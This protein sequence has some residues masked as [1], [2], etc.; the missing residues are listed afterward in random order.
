M[1]SVQ[2]FLESCKAFLSNPVDSVYVDALMKCDSLRQEL[3]FSVLDTSAEILTAS[4][5]LYHLD[6]RK[7]KSV[8]SNLFNL[9]SSRAG[10]TS[11]ALISQYY[12]SK[13]LT[14]SRMVRY[15]NKVSAVFEQVSRR[16]N[17]RED[18]SRVKR[19]ADMLESKVDAM[20]H[21]MK[22][23]KQR[24]GIPDAPQAGSGT[25]GQYYLQA[26]DDERVAIAKGVQMNLIGKR[27]FEGDS[28]IPLRD[29]QLVSAL[30]MHL[31]SQCGG[32]VETVGEDRFKEAFQHLYNRE[33]GAYE[34]K[35]PLQHQ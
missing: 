32:R 25:W 28:V 5:V 22:M 1:A 18:I 29:V 9:W 11:D 34:I 15:S 6:G 26:T 4:I 7:S 27:E 16:D 19:K 14:P 33:R 17:M 23:A 35:V 13:R 8:M 30:L 2:Q 21:E 24:L 20:Q 3:N 31:L 10:L 12:S